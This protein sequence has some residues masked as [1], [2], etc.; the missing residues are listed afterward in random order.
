LFDPLL[1][2][3][4]ADEL[5]VGREEAHLRTAIG[6]VYY[7]LFVKTRDEL[8]SAGRLQPRGDD[9]D[10]R[11]VVACLQVRRGNAALILSRLRRERNASDYEPNVEMG[12]STWMS[13][14]RDCDDY[15]R[16]VSPDWS[17][18]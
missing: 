13:V 8:E 10:H 6:R 16:L 5:A 17:G 7:A 15:L 12:Y 1:W 3:G 4:V 14:R 18:P 9:S 2:I 11:A